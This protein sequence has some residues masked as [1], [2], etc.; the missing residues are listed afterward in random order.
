M[1]GTISMISAVIL[2]SGAASEAPV[3]S[4]LR[5]HGLDVS[6]VVGGSL[7]ATG[8]AAAFAS[9]LGE[10]RIDGADPSPAFLV[11][12]ERRT[13]LSGAELPDSLGNEVVGIEIQR[14]PDFGPT[15]F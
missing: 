12:G 4:V 14:A 5:S 3:T 11:D 10:T 7:I 6:R 15:D 13:G 1:S 2:L 9:L 8:D